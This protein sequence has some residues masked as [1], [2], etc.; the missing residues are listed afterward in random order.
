[1]S[2]RQRCAPSSPLIRLGAFAALRA[3]SLL[4]PQGEKEERSARLNGNA[5]ARLRGDTG[6]GEGDVEREEQRQRVVE[7][8][9]PNRS[10]PMPMT[11]GPTSMPRP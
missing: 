1:M 9:G 5:L 3:P 7:A 6:D 8:V 2:G 10:M 4:L 11:C